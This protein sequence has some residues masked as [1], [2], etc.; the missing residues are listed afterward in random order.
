MLPLLFVLT[1]CLLLP[2]CYKSS[3]N[4]SVVNSTQAKSTLAIVPLIDHSNHDLS[5]NLSQEFTQLICGRLDKQDRLS[6]TPLNKVR[7]VTN[8]LNRSNDPF[9]ID[10]S[11]IKQA[12]NGNDFVAFME[13]LEHD[14]LPTHHITSSSG[15]DTKLEIAIKV[16]VFD[17]RGSSPKIILQ[18][19]DRSTHHLARQFNKTN[20]YQVPWGDEAFDISPLGMI[21][22]KVTKKLAA[23][24]EE[25]IMLSS[26]K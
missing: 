12:F 14:E 3:S 15:S 11:W 19:I 23:R 8:K 5:W 22:M 13:I 20:F 17:N 6:L 4:T 10:Y 18:E 16:R 2:S 25:Y 24:I 9:G 21:H 26:K 1:T 7:S